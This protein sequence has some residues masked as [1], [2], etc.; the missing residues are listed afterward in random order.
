MLAS[1]S[2][3][4]SSS[5]PRTRRSRSAFS[6]ATWPASRS[7][8]SAQ[9]CS[10]PGCHAGEGRRRRRRR[11]RRRRLHRLA[12]RRHAG[13]PRRTGRGG[14]G[15]HPRRPRRRGGRHMAGVPH[16]RTAVTAAPYCR[17]RRCEQDRR[18]AALG[19]QELAQRAL[20]PARPR[21]C[22]RPEVRAGGHI[23][24]PRSRLGR[25]RRARRPAGDGRPSRTRGPL[26]WSSRASA[27]FG[28]S[29]DRRGVAETCRPRAGPR[30]PA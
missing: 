24:P 12:A 20:E 6:S 21:G 13:L 16:H 3:A 11:E 29:R 1:R 10:S 30:V 4:T 2:T 23:R 17:R 5:G 22:P 7:A 18:A 26:A 9:R 8:S 27:G 14:Q 15:R 28:R 19:A 25:D